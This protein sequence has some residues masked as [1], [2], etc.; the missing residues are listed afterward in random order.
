MGGLSAAAVAP[1]EG[2]PWPGFVVATGRLA[3][4]AGGLAERHLAVHGA[5]LRIADEQTG[6]RAGHADGPVR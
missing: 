5:K 3:F 2:P 1:G 4:R 6:V